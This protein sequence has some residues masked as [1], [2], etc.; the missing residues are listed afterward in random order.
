MREGI[1][2]RGN[3]ILA[4]VVLPRR[5]PRPQEVGET[6]RIIRATLFDMDGTL[7]DSEAHT[8]ASIADVM[9][10]YGVQ[11]AYLPSTMTRG[12]TWESICV[13]LRS[14]YP[15]AGEMPNL[16]QELADRFDELV[17][18]QII[19]ITGARE[20]LKEA[21]MHM[22]TAI[23]S[24]SPTDLIRKL[25]HAW[26]LEAW[27][28]AEHCIG[29]EQMKHSKPNPEGYLLAAERLGVDPSHC[30]IFEDSF[31]GLSAAR[32]SGGYTVAILEAAG[33]HTEFQTIADVGLQSFGELRHSFWSELQAGKTL[34]WEPSR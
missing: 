28:P 27:Y 18:R 6:G 17:H 15:S 23:V 13:A 33:E 29:G 14:K 3:D 22:P 8:G 30:L 4:N 20:A 2:E 12:C 34:N 31:A 7:I 9:E 19:P 11:D 1:I 21:A 32:S 5:A 26:E 24:S 10:R 25:V 16:L